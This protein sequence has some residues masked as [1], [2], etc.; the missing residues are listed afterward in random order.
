MTNTDHLQGAIEHAIEVDRRHGRVPAEETNVMPFEE[1]GPVVA[2][3]M[4][5]EE[6]DRWCAIAA[7]VNELTEEANEIS[8]DA[9]ERH[10]K[11]VRESRE[12]RRVRECPSDPGTGQVYTCQ[13]IGCPVHGERN[14]TSP[15]A[16]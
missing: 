10:M 3:A 11:T 14:R 16:S 2:A 1:V 15:P 6:R 5:R 12:A 9:L 13:D 8:K 4:T 7:L